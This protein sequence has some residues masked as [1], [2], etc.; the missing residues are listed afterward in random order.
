MR[1][2]PVWLFVVAFLS[3]VSAAALGADRPI[4][5]TAAKPPTRVL[6]LG[7]GGHH[8]PAQRFAQLE[9]VLAARGIE[10]VY[11]D[12][13]EDLDSRVLG[14]YDALAVYANIDTL[15]ADREAAIL[16]FVRNGKGLV[17]LHCASFCFRNSPTWIDLVGAQFQ[18]H[19]VGEFRTVNVEIGRA[20]V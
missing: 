15:P 10:L 6:F 20:H 2:F 1:R 12:R 7:D 18:K 14:Q 13:L 19:G 9:P 17:P 5:A 16:E 3:M 8:Q 4:K 11:T